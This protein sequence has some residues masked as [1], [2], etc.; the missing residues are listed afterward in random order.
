M[1]NENFLLIGALLLFVAVLAGKAAYRLGAPA[2]LLFLGG[3]RRTNR[4]LAI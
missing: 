2:L 4:Y 1:L 3:C